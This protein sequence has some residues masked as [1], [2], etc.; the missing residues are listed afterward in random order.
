MNIILITHPTFSRS[1]SMPKFAQ[2]I[3]DGMFR[4]GHNVIVVSPKPFFYNLPFP[5]KVKK[6]FGYIDQFIIFPFR[7]NKYKKYATVHKDT[8]FVFVDQALGPWIPKFIDYPQVIH[9]HDFLA[10]RSAE[11][12][13]EDNK[14]SLTGKIYQWYIKWGF[15]KGKNFI[16]VSNNTR[17][18]LEDIM[19]G[20]QIVTK[21]IYNGLDPEIKPIE[22]QEALMCCAKYI[23]LNILKQGFLLHVGGNQWYKNRLGLIEIYDEYC[24][25]TARESLP[26]IMVGIEPSESI[27]SR[28]N[29]SKF[30]S[31]IFFISGVDNKGLS[32][33]YSLAKL[34]IFPSKYEGFGWPVA[35]A[36]KCGCPVLTT[37]EPPMNEVGAKAAFYIP[38][39]KT[40]GDEKEW[41]KESAAKVKEIIELKTPEIE[42]NI[43]M[44]FEQIKLFD[45]ETILDSYQDFYQNAMN[46]K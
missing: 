7:L 10:L 17:H 29:S 28:Y 33:F 21:T 22:R 1:R 30:K 18:E 23:D 24:Q 34:F 25:L 15:S 12:I 13:H 8:L 14:V 19:K 42:K 6:W 3:K 40:N 26:I 35:E 45:I 39:F 27:I 4:R 16:C 37:N 44:G 43:N 41:A 5:R 11:N 20:K 2:L 38:L 46:L 36:M 31:N 9:V 32:S